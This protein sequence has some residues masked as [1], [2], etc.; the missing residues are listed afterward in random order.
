MPYSCRMPRPAS[1]I[2]RDKKLTV[3]LSTGELTQLRQLAKKRGLSVSDWVRQTVRAATT[4]KTHY[5]DTMKES[6]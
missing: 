3:M 5:P 6:R 1:T 4:I 2:K